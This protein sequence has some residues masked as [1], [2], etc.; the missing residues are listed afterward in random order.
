MMKNVI[1]L[2]LIV[3]LAGCWKGPKIFQIPVGTKKG[4]A[5]ALVRDHKKEAVEILDTTLK[6]Y[7]E[8]STR[9][10]VVKKDTF[11]ISQVQT[12]TVFKDRPIVD[13]VAFKKFIA[14][15]LDAMDSLKFLIADRDQAYQILTR[16]AMEFYENGL[17][18]KDT[19][20]TDTLGV[21]LKVYIVKN[22]L[23]AEVRRAEQKYAYD[24]HINQTDI[25]PAF[26][27]RNWW[28]FYE[29]WISLGFN[30]LL[31]LLLISIIRTVN[32]R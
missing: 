29:T 28:R 8:F 19:L 17:V 31:F 4:R 22:T 10:T 7:P 23:I 6:L 18:T 20:I 24:K 14:E 11:R 30:L 32:R 1:L 21:R 12:K 15:Q 26:I 9:T 16:K 27:Y 13:T 3:S 25:K 2:L 5:I